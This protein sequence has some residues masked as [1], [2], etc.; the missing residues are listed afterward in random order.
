MAMLDQA[1]R[2]MYEE[3]RRS[4]QTENRNMPVTV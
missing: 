1:D 2:R 4:G 3:K